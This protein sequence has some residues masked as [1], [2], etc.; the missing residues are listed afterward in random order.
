MVIA[1]CVQNIARS[2]PESLSMRERDYVPTDEVHCLDQIFCLI[3]VSY[4]GYM[5]VCF[6]IWML[7]FDLFRSQIESEL[8]YLPHK[9]YVGCATRKVYYIGENSC[10]LACRE[11]DS[12]LRCK[13]RRRLSG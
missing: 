4:L 11:L 5:P 6:F 9:W 8:I 10:Q 12:N 2:P 3:V 7:P 13:R 1:F